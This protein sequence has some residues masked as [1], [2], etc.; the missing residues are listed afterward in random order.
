MA[1]AWTCAFTEWSLVTVTGE[2][3]PPSQLNDSAA[4]SASPEVDTE[5]TSVNAATGWR[6]RPR[7]TR[8]SPVRA[9]RTAVDRFASTPDADT[10]ARLLA[11]LP[12]PSRARP[13]RVMG[14]RTRPPRAVQSCRAL[15]RGD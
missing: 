10:M 5:G 7:G 14:Q 11:R 2:L 13:S 3:L 15:Q 12:P 8:R 9:G 1:P 4:R 6:L